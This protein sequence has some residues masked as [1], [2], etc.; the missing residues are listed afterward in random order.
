MFVSAPYLST[1]GTANWL[2][3]I[4]STRRHNYLTYEDA[5]AD[6]E[7]YSGSHNATVG[8]RTRVNMQRGIVTWK[9]YLNTPYESLAVQYIPRGSAYRVSRQG[10]GSQ[11]RFAIEAFFGFGAGYSGGNQTGVSFPH[12]NFNWQTISQRPSH[13]AN[14]VFIQNLRNRVENEA[15][16]KLRDQRIDLSESLVD[17]RQSVMMVAQRT[18]QVLRAYTAIRGGRFREGLRTL[19][20]TRRNLT[21]QTPAKLWLEVSY[22]WKPLLADIHSGIETV[23]NGLARES[24]QFVVT[25][26]GSCTLVPDS[27]ITGTYWTGISTSGSVK[28]H[29][30]TKYRMKVSN[31]SLAYLTQL[32]LDNPA[33]IAWISLPMSFVVD[34]L[35]PV[36]DWLRGI[37]SPLGLEFTSG[38]TT[39]KVD[40]AFTGS[41]SLSNVGTYST[42]VET[43]GNCSYECRLNHMRR[44][45]HTTLPMTNIYFRFPFSSNQRI[46]SAVALLEVTLN[47]RR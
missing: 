2:D 26:R 14:R 29:V 40:G 18:S 4:R 34:W 32:G 25:R 3:V 28:G 46:A 38:Y 27:Q 41:A 8:R 11:A 13:I 6:R 47:R 12:T 20:I 5:L 15:K 21:S 17:I 45:P 23:N 33:Y 30:E 7:N 1:N 31:P 10:S 16:L 35:A 22:G 19:G 36:S 43:A 44:Y 42:V 24:E 37:T 39:V 9:T